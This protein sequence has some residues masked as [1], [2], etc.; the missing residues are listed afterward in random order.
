MR[1]RA[2]GLLIVDGKLLLIHRIR[3]D[4]GIKR[5]YYVVPGGGNNQGET[6]RETVVREIKEEIGI[7]VRVISDE[8]R[9]KYETEEDKQYFFLVE[10]LNGEIGTGNGPEYTEYVNM[11]KY[12]PELIPV[13]DIIAGKINMVPEEIKEEFIRDIIKLE[14]DRLSSIDLI[15]MK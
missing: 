10:Y 12:L 3:E 8:P 2:G 6:L 11:G 1:I 15:K 5:E 7:E 9:Y 13:K 14:V 4:N